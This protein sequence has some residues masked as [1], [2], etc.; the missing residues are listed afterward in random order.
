MTAK[1]LDRPWLALALALAL[2]LVLALVCAACSLDH[3][4]AQ[5]ALYPESG[6]GAVDTPKAGAGA[7]DAGH[8]GSRPAA[9]GSGAISGRSGGG[10]G[11][12]GVVDECPADPN[13]TSPGVCGCGRSEADR[14]GDGTPDCREPAAPGAKCGE[15]VPV[16]DELRQRLN[17]DPFY[18]K[19]TDAS[20]V[21]VLSSA[22]PADESLIAACLLIEAMLSKRSDV[23]AAMVSAGERFAIIGK[24][25]GT[26]DIPE[27]RANLSSQSEI[28]AFNRRAR[29][30]AGDVT[31]CGEEN[32]LCL[33]GDPYDDESICIFNFANAITMYGTNAVDPT[34]DMRLRQLYMRA[35]MSGILDGTYRNQDKASYWA[36]GVQDYYDTNAEADPPDG[37]HNSVNTRAELKDYDPALYGLIEE[38]LPERLNWHDCHLGP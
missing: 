22:A 8:G 1:A 20:G 9:A 28:D 16:S 38:F 30:V 19:Y 13:K 12:P 3:R 18:K 23:A 35:S 33:D 32:I 24:Q 25:E 6:S 11:S 27:Y 14:D 15:V 17:L 21:P 29:G 37:V 7:D 10:A 26:A 36:E 4:F 2:A 31:S 5:V 34:F